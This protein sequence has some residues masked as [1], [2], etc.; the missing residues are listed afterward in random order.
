MTMS[1]RSNDMTDAE[2][3]NTM[4]PVERLREFNDLCGMV[5]PGDTQKRIACK[6][7]VSRKT[8]SEWHRTSIVPTWA[9]LLVL[10]WSIIGSHQLLPIGSR[11]KTSPAP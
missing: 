2:F 10:A 3:F 1:K 11:Q 4:S 9:L 6:I 7:G 5:F 8:V